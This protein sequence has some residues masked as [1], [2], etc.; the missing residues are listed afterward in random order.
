MSHI[1]KPPPLT[2]KMY[3]ENDNVYIYNGA[4]QIFFET[5]ELIDN[6]D[7]VMHPDHRTNPRFF[8]E[9][10]N[11]LVSQW[12]VPLSALEEWLANSQPK[13]ASTE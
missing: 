7:R 13:N 8:D 10:G 4:I 3:R 6:P 11:C 12:I 5:P 9:N 2:W 1:G